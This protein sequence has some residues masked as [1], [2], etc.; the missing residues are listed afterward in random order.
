MWHIAAYAIINP[1]LWFLDLVQGGGLDWAYWPTIGWGVGLAFHI[2]SYLIDD[3][4]ME[5]RAY[6]KFLAEERAKESS[7]PG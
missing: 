5:G 3:S 6:E 7:T 2:A 1:L 4:G